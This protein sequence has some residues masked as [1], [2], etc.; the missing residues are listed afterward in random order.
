MEKALYKR[1]KGLLICLGLGLALTGC[2][3]ADSAVNSEEK[4][5]L[6]IAYQYGLAYTPVI[7]AKEQNLIEKSYKEITGKE[8]SVVWT[9]M[10]SGADINTGIASGNLD[11]G[12]M[13]TA[14]AI[15]GTL[16][17][18][19]YKVFTNLS[20]QEHRLMTNDET[21]CSLNDLINSN[22]QIA[23]VNIGSIQHII[24]AKS[25]Y[26]AGYDPHILDS[27]LVAMKHT[28]GMTALESGNVA[29]HLT[30]SPYIYMEE[31]NKELHE[32][33]EIS[34]VWSEEDSFIV[35]VASESLYN[36]NQELYLALCDA[37]TEAVDYTN[38]NM[39]EVA[40]ITCELN[41][42]SVD[43]ELEYLQKGNYAVETK[44]LFS[45]AAFMAEAGFIEKAP[46]SYTDLA[47]ENVSGD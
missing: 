25:L 14:P 13:G 41:G 46:E 20:G 26:Q 9:Q 28:D 37:I 27:N 39:E 7:V 33:P 2:K 35:G 17:G 11:V 44:N 12:F 5:T 19:G 22:S 24:L 45:L 8:I 21:L 43:Q 40:K 32:I 15:T 42:N 38:N 18:V 47:F 29:C 30:S 1:I 36:E 6:N 23:L 31:K 10:S 34:E 16:K 3:K 4:I